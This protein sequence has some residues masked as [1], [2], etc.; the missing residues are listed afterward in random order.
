VSHK[1]KNRFTFASDDVQDSYN[2]ES[3]ADTGKIRIKKIESHKVK[4]SPLLA[5]IS[6]AVIAT[7]VVLVIINYYKNNYKQSRIFKTSE[8]ST[9]LSLSEKKDIPTG[10]TSNEKLERGKENY[11]KGYFSNAISMFNEVVESGASDS[12]KAI[13]LTYIGIIHDD[14]SNYNKAIEYYLR[15]LKYDDKSVIAYRNLAI[16][17]RHKK[18][19][20]EAARAVKKGLDIEPANVQNRILLGNILFE[21]GKYKDAISEYEDALKIKPEPAAMHNMALALLTTG[22]ESRAIEYLIKA[23][24]ADNNGNVARLSYSKLG[25]IY[26]N[27]K[28]YESAEKYL[29]MAESLDSKDPVI[30]YN[31]GVA[32]LK[33]KQPER[34]LAEFQKAEELGKNDETL[35]ENLG[36]TYYSLNDYEKSIDAYNRLLNTNKRNIRILSKL[37][38]IY[39]EKGEPEKAFE[40][41]QKITILEPVSENARIAYVNMGN[42]LDDLGR[43]DEAIETYN[44]ALA[45][46]EDDDSTLYNLGIAYKNAGKAELAVKAWRKASD[47]NPDTPKPL[48]AIANLYEEKSMTDEAVEEYQQIIKRWDNHQEAHFNLAVL[49]YKKNLP[50]YAKAEFKKV[51]DL[52]RSNEFA[53]KAYTNLGIILSKTAGSNEKLLDEAQSYVQKAL[54][55]KP[56]DAEA[57]ISLGLIYY[58]KGMLEKA[59]D[60][61][62]LAISSSRDGKILA[63]AYNNI[64]KCYHKKGLYKNALAAFTRGIEEDP[65]SEEIRLNRKVSMQSYESELRR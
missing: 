54:L 56:N 38:E 45:I 55:Q 5:V 59:I 47:L 37:A 61:F 23:G 53:A 51:I 62:N 35:L 41:Y 10:T 39:Y 29:R 14:R 9:T 57:F 65:S 11:N 24:A 49:Y 2:P 6:A 8:D 42:I 13:A 48:M 50:D 7:A 4:V 27:R 3:N 12:E 52:D 46:T 60:T 31:L 36:E 63:E 58:K 15:A 32:Y 26:I 17:Y 16:A 25:V 33:M 19:P 34:A 30:R 22:N 64:G 44:K 18:D 1:R 28:D 21:Q 43:P 40:L 20:E